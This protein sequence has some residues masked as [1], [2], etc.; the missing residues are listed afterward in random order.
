MRVAFVDLRAQHDEIRADL[1]AAIKAV[2]D[3]S[4]F[5]GGRRVATF[6]QNF[7]KFLG[8]SHAAGVGSGTDA[9]RIG[10]Q[11]AGVRP[12]DFVI[13]VPH[14]FI[15][16][17][18]GITQAGATP[19]FVDIHP[20]S[21]N[22]DP[23]A[24]ARLLE[25]SCTPGSGRGAIH[26]ETG[27][28]VAAVLPVHLYGQP[29]DMAPILDLARRFGVAVVE[30]V[31][32]AH[33]A[34]YRFPDGTVR[35]CG[36][37]GDVG[38]FSFYPG[39]NL[40]AIGEAG[41]VVTFD[42]ER[43]RVNRVLRDHGQSQRYV[44]VSPD[45]SNARLDALQA[46]VLTLK[47]ARLKEWN[48]RRRQAAA[49]YREDLADLGELLPA[50]MSYGTHVYHLFVVQVP[51]RERLQAALDQA[52]IGTGLHYPIALH[53]QEAYRSMGLARGAFPVAESV[54]SR[55]LSLPMH[56]HLTREHVRYVAETLRTHLT[57][58]Q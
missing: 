31:A 24:L 40:G 10:L 54:A 14:T 29:A 17:V 20:Q 38:C 41:A 2:L 47:L 18:E 42:A 12:G 43:D 15:A 50:E 53:L 39:K 51:E 32:Q 13:T 56:P 28:T 58:S 8:V 21:Y 5:I 52:G 55:V 30:D 6:E 46:V 7:A 37:M 3:E 23:A 57:R 33:G 48:E 22:M 9:L 27:R 49:W 36:T 44:H 11:A 26:R 19:L 4:A 25:S 1:D 35:S 34:T 45:G 16:T